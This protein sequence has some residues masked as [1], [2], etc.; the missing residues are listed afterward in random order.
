MAGTKRNTP[1]HQ[2]IGKHSRL[3]EFHLCIRVQHVC[4]ALIVELLEMDVDCVACD[5]T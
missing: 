3:Q 1:G 5:H 4:V 2:P